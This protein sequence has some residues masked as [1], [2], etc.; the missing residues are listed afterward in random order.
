M[1]QLGEIQAGNV[2][3]GGAQFFGVFQTFIPQRIRGGDHNRRGQAIQIRVTQ[4]R[5]PVIRHHRGIRNKV[6]AEPGEQRQVQSETL[7]QGLHGF[8]FQRP[9]RGRIDE[10]LQC[11]QRQPRQLGLLADHRA[12]VAAGTVT[13][14]RQSFGIQTQGGGVVQQPAPHGEGIIGTGG[15]GIFR[16]EAVIHTQHHGVGTLGNVAAEPVIFFH[17][18]HGEAATVEVQDGRGQARR[19]LRAIA[20]H[21][22]SCV[23][24]HRH[25]MIHHHRHGTLGHI[26]QRDHVL[27]ELA[28]L[29]HRHRIEGRLGRTE[30]QQQADMRIEMIPAPGFHSRRQPGEHRPGQQHQGFQRGALQGNQV[31]RHSLI[32]AHGGRLAARR[33]QNQRECIRNT[34]PDRPQCL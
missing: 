1:H 31:H 16:G 26:Q 32:S 7:P 8:M 25:L 21:Q 15:R 28:R 13:H 5:H 12:E 30:G 2:H 19:V 6:A 4:G 9:V 18:A 17:P 23:V 24:C 10:H 11:R 22:H 3:A 27:I 20:A 33:K 29:R 34:T 14:D